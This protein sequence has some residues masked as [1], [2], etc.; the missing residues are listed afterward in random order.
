LKRLRTDYIDLYQ[1]HNPTREKIAKGEFFTVLEALKKEGKILHYGM[2]IHSEEEGEA[3]VSDGRS[4]TIQVIVN[5][6]NQF[7]AAKLLPACE[8]KKIGVIAREPLAC[9]ILTGKY[10]G[11]S[12][13]H[14]MDHRNRWPRESLA[15]DL[16]KVKKIS[17]AFDTRKV[18][19]KQAAIEFALSF[20]AVSVVIP[21]MKTA[22]HVRDHLR[23]LE[24]P[25][26]TAA[27]LQAIRACYEQEE[28]FQASGFRN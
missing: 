20:P 28:M 9:G 1:L 19:L 2:S 14:R 24:A 25:K 26:L 12:V 7:A 18:S 8:A 21:G 23:A 13:F 17:E 4:E 6:I 10:H 22:E 11:E 27:E 3:L 5:M 15:R 16:E